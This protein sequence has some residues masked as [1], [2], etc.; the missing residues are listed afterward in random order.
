MVLPS[1]RAPELSVPPNSLTSRVSGESS[2]GIPPYPP[3][4]SSPALTLQHFRPVTLAILVVALP[5]LLALYSGD[6]PTGLRLPMALLAAL[7]Q[8]QPRFMFYRQDSL[9]CHHDQKRS[10]RPLS[11]AVA[12]GSRGETTP[13]ALPATNLQPGS[14]LSSF[15]CPTQ[16]VSGFSPPV[17]TVSLLPTSFNSKNLVFPFSKKDRP[18]L[19]SN[20]FPSTLPCASGW[21]ISRNTCPPSN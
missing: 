17:R 9:R 7:L 18:S 15:P 8:R 6:E 4:E 20:I 2:S 3:N 12:R 16:I 11:F 5:A 1:E 13:A 19:A 14:L 10:S 21:P